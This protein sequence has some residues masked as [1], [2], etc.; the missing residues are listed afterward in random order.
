MAGVVAA[1]QWEESAE[2]LYERYCAARDVEKR[3]RLQALWRVRQG[4]TEAE[5]ARQA[6]VGRR[7]LVRWLSWYRRGGLDE[8][9]R[10]VPGHGA[11]GKPCWLSAA[12]KEELGE[13]CSQGEFRSAPEVRDWVEEQWGVCYGSGGMYTLLARLRIHP[14]VPRPQAEKADPQAQEAWKKGGLHES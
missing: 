10:R 13:R 1:V 6:G 9:L 4:E 11:E 2:D 14:K 8:V 5:A 12:Q 7:T 3:K